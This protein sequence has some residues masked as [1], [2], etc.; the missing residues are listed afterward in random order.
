ML[1]DLAGKSSVVLDLVIRAPS[2]T[3]RVT[4]GTNLGEQLRDTV[5]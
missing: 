1:R 2:D 5:V 4:T 3:W